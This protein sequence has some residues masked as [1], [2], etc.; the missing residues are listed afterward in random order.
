MSPDR[1]LPD[2]ADQLEKP[3]F[4]GKSFVIKGG[5]TG[6]QDLVVHG[7]IEGT[8]SLSGYRITVGSGG[9]VKGDMLAKVIRIAGYAEGELR[10]EEKIFLDRS[11]KVR[12][13]I[14]SPRV[15]L[16]DGCRFSGSIQ[17]HDVGEPNAE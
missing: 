7:R 15:S 12:G 8:V 9:Q 1:T 10:G 5:V 14:T 16:E 4:I 6:D 2:P 13:K 3:A 11:A 17:M